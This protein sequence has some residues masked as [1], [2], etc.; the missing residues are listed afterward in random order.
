MRRAVGRTPKLNGQRPIICPWADPNKLER[1]ERVAVLSRLV[2]DGYG[3]T[4]VPTRNYDQNGMFLS[5]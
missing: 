4:S 5:V 3:I 1:I 2:G